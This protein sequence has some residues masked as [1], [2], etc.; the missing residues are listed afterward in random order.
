MMLILHKFCVKYNTRVVLKVTQFECY[1]LHMICLYKIQ[2][3]QN[4]TFLTRLY[5]QWRKKERARKDKRVPSES[6]VILGVGA[7]A[8]GV[9][10]KSVA[11][12]YVILVR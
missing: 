12:S 5:T 7:V 1:I 4:A 3:R 11:R 6:S 8:R 10:S 9:E 2:T